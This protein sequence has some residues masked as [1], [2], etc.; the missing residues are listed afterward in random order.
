MRPRVIASFASA[1]AMVR[2]LGRFLR[3]ED[4]PRLAMLPPGIEAIAPVV[5]ALPRGVKEAIYTWSGWSEAIA[6]E[7]V[8]RVRAEAISR[9]VVSEYPHR[10]YPAAMVGSSSG[11]A[12]HLC[13]AL[14]IPWLPQT[15]FIPVR[16]AGVH[17][18]EPRLGLEAGREAGQALLAANPDL[19]LHHMHDPVQDRLMIRHM[20]YFRVKRLRLGDTYEQFLADT[21]PSGGT[22]YLLECRQ[23]WPTT[24][25]GERHAFQFGAVGGA[26]PDE[27]LHGSPSV[28][29]Y[30]RRYGSHRRRWDPPPPDGE[31]PEAE[32]GFAEALREDAKR[33]A[34]R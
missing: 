31:R 2:A 18:D 7:E 4:F 12:V 27:Y 9:W 23:P 30:L 10:R 6:Q 3:E 32:W 15:V 5:N 33:L 14:G 29:D 1:S 28:A 34:R 26:A 19:Q 20:T 25:V 24:R 16:Q 22:L 17:P 13:A 8:A 11:A 21:L